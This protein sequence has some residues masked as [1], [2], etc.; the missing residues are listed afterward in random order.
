MIQQSEAK[1]CS[2]QRFKKLLVL[3]SGKRQPPLLFGT[4]R[5]NITVQ[6]EN[7]AMFCSFY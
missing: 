7:E 5:P 1:A 3:Q 6:A 4:D 2:V